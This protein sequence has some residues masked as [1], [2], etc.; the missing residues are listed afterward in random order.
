[1]K[2]CKRG[3]YRSRHKIPW[4]TL[5]NRMISHHLKNDGREDNCEECEGEDM[6]DD[7]GETLDETFHDKRENEDD[8][9]E[10]MMTV[11]TLQTILWMI[12]WINSMNS[13]MMVVQFHLT[14]LMY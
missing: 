13:S 10:T 4:Q 9:Q 14:L 11:K 12:P 1:M 8:E 3:P 7:L 5:H 2:R 6:S